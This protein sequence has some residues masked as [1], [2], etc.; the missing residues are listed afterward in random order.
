MKIARKTPRP[1][2]ILLI[3]FL[4]LVITVFLLTAIL[5]IVSRYNISFIK[6]DLFKEGIIHNLLLKIIP[7]GKESIGI[8]VLTG[9]IVI[10]IFLFLGMWKRSRVLWCFE[11]IVSILFIGGSLGFDFYKE[12]LNLIKMTLDE[13]LFMVIIRTL[14][15]TL[16]IMMFLYLTKNRVRDYFG[17]FKRDLK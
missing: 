10:F 15:L 14:L 9:V 3:S 8:S 2:G 12:H 17:I 16:G 11:I 13:E 6:Y 5:A 7:N 1:A 4:K